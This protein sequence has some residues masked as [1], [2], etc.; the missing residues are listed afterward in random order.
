MST[1]EHSFLTIV[2][3][4]G[5]SKYHI[6]KN[7]AILF[8]ESLEISISEKFPNGLGTRKQPI[9]LTGDE[10]RKLIKQLDEVV[11]SH[12]AESSD[13]SSDDEEETIQR[14]LAH[15]IKSQSSQKSIEEEN[16]SD[17][18][19][20]DVI[21]HSRRFRHLYSEIKS[22]KTKINSLIEK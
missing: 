16:I 1:P 14:V 9:T 20:E 22:L 4:P 10:L 12:E 5:K 8:S 15:R 7:S 11:R 6:Y 2:E 17:S 13:E 18:E 3:C 19:N 21:S